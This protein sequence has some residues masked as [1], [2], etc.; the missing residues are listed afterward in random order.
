MNVIISPHGTIAMSTTTLPL[1]TQPFSAA[2]SQKFINDFNRDGCVHLG[3]LL[4]P[5]EVTALKAGIDDAFA[6]PQGQAA[7]RIYSD[8]V[9]VRLFETSMFLRDMLVREPIITLMEQLLGENCHLMANN[10]VRNPPGKAIDTFHVDDTL[11]FP[12]PADIPR[13]DPR[14]TIPTFMLNVQIALTDIPTDAHGPTQY[15]PGSHYS[16]RQPNDPK[17]PSFEGRTPVSILCKAGDVYLQ[18]SQ[19]WHRGAPNTSN[20]TRY[21]YQMAFCKRLIGQR[22][23]PFLNYHMPDHVLNGASDRLRRVLGQHPKGPYG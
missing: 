9:C 22:F 3:T 13:F 16:G 19:V 6:D 2:Q 5:E 4:S 20:Q 21:L 23:F 15:V 1:T 8:T 7:H 17:N 11:C 10:A 12:L 14:I 18:H